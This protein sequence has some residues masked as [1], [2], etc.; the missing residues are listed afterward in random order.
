MCL[1]KA[2]KKV[3]LILRSEGSEMEMPGRTQSASLMLQSGG[4]MSGVRIGGMQ[5]FRQNQR[6]GHHQ[7]WQ[8]AQQTNGRRC[9]WHG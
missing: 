9:R 2:K 5:W 4:G 8:R 6:G 3:V 1:G 7:F